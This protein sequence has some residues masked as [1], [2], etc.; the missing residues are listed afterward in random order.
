MHRKGYYVDMY[1]KV[2][3]RIYFLDSFNLQNTKRSSISMSTNTIKS[4]EGDSLNNGLLFQPI[5]R[6]E[7]F[8]LSP[9]KSMD[10]PSAGMMQTSTLIISTPPQYHYYL[11]PPSISKKNSRTNVSMNS[12]STNSTSSS[13][14]SCEYDDESLSYSFYPKSNQSTK[15]VILS[16]SV[17]NFWPPPPSPSQLN[18]DPEQII[19][20]STIE[21][22][23]SLHR[24]FIN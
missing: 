16:D 2:F 14:S 4:N 3:Y 23:N 15:P 21:Q 19:M 10:E 5:K 6:K 18:N 22:V 17:Q 1:M 7:S 11:Y 12:I 20:A 9:P 13:S 24:S 8:Y